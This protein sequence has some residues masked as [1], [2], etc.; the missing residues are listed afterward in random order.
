MYQ[1]FFHWHEKLC[2][3][4]VPGVREPWQ[5]VVIICAGCNFTFFGVFQVSVWNV[6]S[7]ADLACHLSSLGWGNEFSP[8]FACSFIS[9]FPF[10]SLYKKWFV[11][12][13]S[14]AHTPNSHRQRWKACFSCFIPVR[15]VVHNC[16]LD[17]SSGFPPFPPKLF[18]RNNYPLHIWLRQK[19]GGDSAFYLDKLLDS[20]VPWAITKSLAGF[21]GGTHVLYRIYTTGMTHGKPWIAQSTEA[22][23]LNRTDRQLFM[24][25]LHVQTVH[26]GHRYWITAL[27]STELCVHI[28]LEWFPP[29]TFKLCRCKTS[30]SPCNKNRCS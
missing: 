7:A 17:S 30:Q 12:S 4:A 28:C 15:L 23:Q 16:H 19:S 26:V 25:N 14:H 1:D 29:V 22:Q 9:L 8:M 18:R 5:K 3:L 20:V 10:F 13:S 11:R 2:S 21:Y 6:G 27:P 24:L